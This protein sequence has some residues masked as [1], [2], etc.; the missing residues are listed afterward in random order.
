MSGDRFDVRAR[1]H[2][3]EKELK[4]LY[5]IRHEMRKLAD[6]GSEADKENLK[7]VEAGIATA[8][9]KEEALREDQ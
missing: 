2:R 6:K 4:E 1:L 8:L 7:S 9:T 3:L 5:R